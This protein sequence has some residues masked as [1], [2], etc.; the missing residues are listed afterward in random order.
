MNIITHTLC[1]FAGFLLGIFAYPIKQKITKILFVPKLSS[2]V[3][4]DLTKRK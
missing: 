3:I 4:Q 2:D 1:I